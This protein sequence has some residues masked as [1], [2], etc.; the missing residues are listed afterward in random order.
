MAVP[1]NPKTKYLGKGSFG[2][3]VQPALPNVN[4]SGQWTQYPQ[5]VSKIFRSKNEYNLAMTRTRK[6]HNIMGKNKGHRLNTY[7]HKYTTANNLPNNVRKNC[8]FE[9]G[10]PIHV[11][12]LPYLGISVW[13][14][15]DNIPLLQTIP[16]SK[17]VQQIQKL[18]TQVQSLQKANYI[19]GDIRQQNVMIDPKTGDMTII[20]FDWLLPYE[21]F[22][23]SYPPG[24][25]SNPP[26]SLLFSELQTEVDASTDIS[27]EID[28]YYMNLVGNSDRRTLAK[29]FINYYTQL[30]ISAKMGILRLEDLKPVFRDTLMFY[31]DTYRDLLDKPRSAVA[32]QFLAKTFDSY[33][34]G[35]TLYQL[36]N[37]LY[38]GQNVQDIY[39]RMKT[40]K[41]EEGARI[42]ILVY[43][44]KEICVS[45]AHCKMRERITIDEAIRK[46]NAIPRID[47][48]LEC[49]GGLC[50]I[51]GGRRTH[52]HNRRTQSLRKR[53]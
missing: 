9:I 43:R 41:G 35:F 26:E 3:V 2:C 36:L 19:H 40:V 46:L 10:E 30:D 37:Y 23:N 11:S 6:A 47:Q 12:K 50:K 27:R 42:A 28:T 16:F 39:T 29:Q 49:S 21:E 13:D 4:E 5:N 51:M 44:I 32:D 17:L 24:F 53:R 18:F 48:Y 45:M 31:Q 20:D 8:K 33:G 15:K 14:A 1:I 38:P 22:M 52:R 34:L 7:K 25:Y